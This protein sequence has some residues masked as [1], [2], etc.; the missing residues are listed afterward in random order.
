MSSPKKISYSAHASTVM[1]ERELKPEWVEL[2]ARAPAW[3]EDEPGHPEVER[4]FRAV[5]DRG[6]RILRVAVVE[7]DMEI[8]IVTAFLDRRARQP[9]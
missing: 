1:R 7:T 3:R 2:A 4:R 8:R 9:E 5:P 6:G